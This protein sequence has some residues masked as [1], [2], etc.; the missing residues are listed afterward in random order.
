[1]APAE[2]AWLGP[3]DERGA[4]GSRAGGAAAGA[5]RRPQLGVAAARCAALWRHAG[6]AT[7]LR[8]FLQRTRAAAGRLAAGDGSSACAVWH[9]M[10][11]RS[12][13]WEAG[14]LNNA[15]APQEPFVAWCQVF[16]LCV[17]V[18]G[19]PYALQ[20]LSAV[21]PGGSPALLYL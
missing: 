13:F 12:L 20:Q 15:S 10:W 21:F 4:R 8:V 14:D 1:M 3:C 11:G 2:R 9:S 5:E 7:G 6:A 17:S 18:F 16:L 19:A